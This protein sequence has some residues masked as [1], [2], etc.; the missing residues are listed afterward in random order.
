MYKYFL[1]VLHIHAFVYI[2]KI[3]VLFFSL[4]VCYHS[5]IICQNNSVFLS[6]FKACKVK[7]IKFILTTGEYSQ[8]YRVYDCSVIWG[9][10][11]WCN[12]QAK[13]QEI[14]QG[15]R[16]CKHT[17][18]NAFLRNVHSNQHFFCYICA[19]RF[20]TYVHSQMVV[21]MSIRG[22]PEDV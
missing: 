10:A 8:R 3:S 21:S 14:R 13:S 19:S 12:F 15:F 17:L 20:L 1:T 5:P 2:D 16:P 11:F 7:E 9:V 18:S 22:C 4:Y 6:S